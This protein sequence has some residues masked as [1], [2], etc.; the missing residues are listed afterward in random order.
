MAGTIAQREL[1]NQNAEVIAKVAAGES[2]VITRHGQPVAELR[3]VST[4]QRTFVSKA[5]ILRVASRGVHLDAAAFRRDL[6]EL[7]DQSVSG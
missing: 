1:R 6:D 4:P 2:F 5:E 3:P 7:A